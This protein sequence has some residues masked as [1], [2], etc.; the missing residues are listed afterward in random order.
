MGQTKWRQEGGECSQGNVFGGV[1]VRLSANL[2]VKFSV[3]IQ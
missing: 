2:L 1:D 3:S